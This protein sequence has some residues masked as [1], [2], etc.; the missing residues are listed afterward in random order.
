MSGRSTAISNDC[1]KSSE[2]LTR[3]SIR[4]RRSTASGTVLPTP[5]AANRRAENQ[6]NF[7]L[8]L[9]CRAEE[10]APLSLAETTIRR[11]F[12]GRGE[13]RH[14]PGRDMVIF[15]GASEVLSL[16]ANF[17]IGAPSLGRSDLL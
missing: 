9:R 17:E 5:A 15:A 14:Q 8:T 4:S 16:Q 3:N 12:L 1:A 6:A 7:V 2:A 11:H 13:F 10:T